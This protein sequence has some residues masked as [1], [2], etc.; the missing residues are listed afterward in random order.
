MPPQESRAKAKSL[1]KSST[2]VHSNKRDLEDGIEGVHSPLEVLYDIYPGSHTAYATA[3]ES[4]SIIGL[5]EDI[6]SA[7]S[8]GSLRE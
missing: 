8:T 4:E 1:S 7:V 5:F 2:T 3:G 6:E